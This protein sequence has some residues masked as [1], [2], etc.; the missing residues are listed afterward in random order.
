MK[1][2]DPFVRPTAGLRQV[3]TPGFFDALMEKYGDPG[4]SRPKGFYP[5]LDQVTV[6]AIAIERKTGKA[7]PL[8]AVQN[9]WPAA[10]NTKT[11]NITLR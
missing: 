5:R 2:D 8:P 11:P 7:T 1:A 10:D 9:R 6:Y 4:W 3:H